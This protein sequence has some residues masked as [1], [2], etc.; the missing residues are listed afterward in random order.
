MKDKD[1]MKTYM[2]ECVAKLKQLEPLFKLLK[3]TRK[4]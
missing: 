1:F 3:K 2:T 4:N